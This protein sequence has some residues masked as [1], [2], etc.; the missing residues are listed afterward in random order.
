MDAYLFCLWS[1]ACPTYLSVSQLL[2]ILESLLAVIFQAS[3]GPNYSQIGCDVVLNVIHIV[4]PLIT[5]ESPSLEYLSL[6]H[7]Q[8]YETTATITGAKLGLE[9]GW[10]DT[11]WK[12]LDLIMKVMYLMMFKRRSLIAVGHKSTCQIDVLWCCYST[13]SE[14]PAPSTWELFSES[15]VTPNE[16]SVMAQ[17]GL[18]LHVKP[19]WNVYSSLTPLLSQLGCVN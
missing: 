3:N 8:L 12:G 5:Q 15:L 6:I 9:S 7:L 14:I 4:T 2:D 18:W 11:N 17:S 19:I 16:S 1:K 10:K 13:H